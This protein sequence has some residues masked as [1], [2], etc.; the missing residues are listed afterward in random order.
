MK[1]F[2]Q[3]IRSQSA[4][5]DPEGGGVHIIWVKE[6]EYMYSGGPSLRQAQRP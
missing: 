2:S 6:P 5:K 1:V 3:I 4:N